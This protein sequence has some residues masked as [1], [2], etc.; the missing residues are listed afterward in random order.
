MTDLVSSISLDEWKAALDAYDERITTHSKTSKRRTHLVGLDHLVREK[1]AA[2]IKTRHDDEGGAYFTKEEICK[3]VEWKITRGRFRPLM[4]YANSLNAAE[5]RS[6]TKEA[7]VSDLNEGMNKLTSLKGIGPATASAILSFG[8]PDEA[9]PFLSDEVMRAVGVVN[10]AGKLDYTI[11]SWETIREKC[12]VK[13]SELNKLRD[14]EDS[15]IIWT[16]VKVERALWAATV[17]EE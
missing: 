14:D 9:C 10:K 13:A 5:V 8:R 2:V 1:Y 15:D 17:G 7:F 4:K 12:E 3:I 16:P 6:L 11:K